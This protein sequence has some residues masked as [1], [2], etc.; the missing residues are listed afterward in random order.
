MVLSTW[1][2]II[3][4]YQFHQPTTEKIKKNNFLGLVPNFHLF[5]P[6]PFLGIYIIRYSVRNRL[7]TIRL[8]EELS[9][10]GGP[11]LWGAN[12]RIVKCLNTICRYLPKQGLININYRLLL[13][14]VKSDARKKAHTGRIRFSIYL[15][16]NNEEKLLFKSRSHAL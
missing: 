11:E 15:L 10:I 5:S 3:F 1:L 2:M 8:T 13:T 6:K 16:A 14:F 9:Y 12:R 4:I 7:R